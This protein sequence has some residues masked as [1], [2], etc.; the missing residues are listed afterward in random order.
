MYMANEDTCMVNTGGDLT[1]KSIDHLAEA[2]AG[3]QGHTGLLADNTLD[4]LQAAPELPAAWQGVWVEM[5]CVRC[6]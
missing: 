1:A 2:G 5:F 3:E 6:T 4:D